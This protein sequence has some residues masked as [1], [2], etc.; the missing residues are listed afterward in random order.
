MLA[1]A[2]EITGLAGEN[3]R[4]MLDWLPK[5]RQL[6]TIKRDVPLDVRIDELKIK[7]NPEL[8]RAQYDRFGFKSWL[9]EVEGGAVPS[10]PAPAPSAGRVSGARSARSSPKTS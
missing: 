1:H 6:L 10:A 5:A 8:Q 9:K 7:P 4:K 3:L 2:D